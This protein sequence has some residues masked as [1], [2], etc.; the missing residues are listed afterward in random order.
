MS[1][2]ECQF[3]QERHWTTIRDDENT[4]IQCL[5]DAH[6]KLSYFQKDKI[7]DKCTFMPITINYCP[8]CGRKLSE[9]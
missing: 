4:F 7:E 8:W 2:K 1:S 9:V 5:L 3:C 6:N